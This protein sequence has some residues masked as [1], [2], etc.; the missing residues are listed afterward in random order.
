M[1]QINKSLQE[2]LSRCLL[3][4]LL[5][6]PVQFFCLTEASA[7]V[8]SAPTEAIASAATT[9][10]ATTST[11]TTSTTTATNFSQQYTQ[12]TKEILQHGIEIERFS[13]H[14]RLESTK[15]P[16]FRR[17]RYFLSQQAGAAG[18]MAF[19]VT[20]VDQFGVG[21]KRPLKID[22]R[23]LRGSLA[24]TTTTLI[25]ASTGS[26]FELSSNVLQMI[27]NK[28]HGYDPKSANNYVAKK[29][30]RIDELLAQ[31]DA[32]V[33]AHSDDPSYAKAVAEG[34]VLRDMRS[35]F[36]DEY[37]HFNADT[38]A[39]R[40][41]Q[42]MFYLLNATYNGIGA[43]AAD[44]GYRALA[45][46]HLNGTTNVLFIVTGGL[47]TVT[48]IICQAT[49]YY[50]RHR[51]YKNLKKEV[52]SDQFNREQFAI[53][54]KNLE[55]SSGSIDGSLIHS[56]PVTE[57]AAMYNQSRELFTKQLDSETKTMR[58]LEKV[59]LQSSI[60]G[61]AIGST[62][63]TQGILGTYG[64][65]HYPIQP[66]KQINQ[67]YCGAIVGCVGAGASLVGNT[68]SLLAGYS[69]EHK[70]WKQKT[71]PKQLIEQRLAHLD[72]V[73]KTVQSLQ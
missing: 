65:Y 14:F 23:A 53:D 48:P 22:S 3:A 27:K 72:E 55:T 7:Q 52:G 59:A 45:R 61:P 8:A 30:H 35:S 38:G 26:M 34:K 33:Q 15:Q 64:Y 18:I 63:L 57:R 49:G 24:A 13:L 5:C 58:K 10:A 37:S 39:Y 2:A 40:A 60:L 54:C 32:I 66:R 62:L 11:A 6:Q 69:Y 9:S 51:A 36:L 21:R 25:I 42:N 29:L 73:E 68:S 31:R 67:F 41:Y 1:S 4:L 56:L 20:A 16:R 12:I 70:L 19:E 50:A 71:L 28:Q 17:L 44:T 43:W 47:A 46:P